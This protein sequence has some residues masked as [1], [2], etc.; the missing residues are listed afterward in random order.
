MR[1]TPGFGGSAR[2]SARHRRR[3]LL[4]PSG[5]WAVFSGTSAATPIISAAYALASDTSD[6]EYPA[7]KAYANP[8][9]F[10][11]VAEGANWAATATTS[12]TP[13]PAMTV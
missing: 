13:A 9:S 4:A 12:A 8:E 6:L 7:S 10:N 5:G 2:Q 11:D 1:D 3:D